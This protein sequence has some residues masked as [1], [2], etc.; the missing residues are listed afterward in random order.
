MSAAIISPTNGDVSL[1]ASTDSGISVNGDMSENAKKKWYQEYAKKFKANRR[2]SEGY[3]K[4]VG[5]VQ[6]FV[7]YYVA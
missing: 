1:V 7:D 5:R 3:V 6:I 2:T 4:V